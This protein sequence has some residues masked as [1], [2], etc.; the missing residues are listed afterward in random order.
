MIDLLVAL[1]IIAGLAGALLIFFFFKS[2]IRVG[3]LNQHY[4]DPVAGVNGR[5]VFYLFRFRIRCLPGGLERKNEIMTWYLPC[6]LIGIVAAWFVL[7]TF[8]FSLLL[9][10]FSA[11]KTFLAAL[12]AS[13]S[14]LSTLGFSTPSTT[15]GQIIAICE[16]AIGLF[17]VVYLFTFL[18]GFMDL[19]RERGSRVAWIYHR[20]GPTPSGVTFL[21]WMARSG[22]FAD[23]P[24]ISEDWGKFFH[25]LANS[26]SFLPI[27][28]IMR[29]LTPENSWICAFAAFLDAQALLTTT[30]AGAS[31][32]SRICFDNGVNAIRNTHFA[33]RGTPVSPRRDPALMRVK[34]SQYDAA[35]AQLEAAGVPLVADRETAW[36]NFAEA[37][38]AYEEEV[39]WLAAAISDPVP[40]WP[41]ASEPGPSR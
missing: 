14:A 40:A 20:T 5:A 37:H 16:G 18:P 35:C 12:I 23:L 1:R 17:L 25:M 7:V 10:A 24:A 39:A 27:L 41:A 11:E 38:M 15:A 32:D 4:Q 2:I 22:R 31:G 13:G 6:V 34:R 9:L 26:R 30:V 21:L 19:I 33:M 29:P 36:K 3:I 28:C 8:A